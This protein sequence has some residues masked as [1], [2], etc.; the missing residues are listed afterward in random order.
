[1]SKRKPLPPTYLISSIIAMLVLNFVFP[2]SRVIRFP[3]NLL[4]IVPLAIGIIVNLVADKA[5]KKTDTTVKPFE[6]STTLITTGVFRISRH[7]MYVGMVLILIGIAVLMGSLTP[8]SVI[9]VFV[10]LME[11]VFIRV[12]ERMLEEKFGGAWSAYKGKVR[13]WI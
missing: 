2:V 5:F 3:W 10:V 1:M 9:F 7:P 13:R 8:Y 11:I 6:D 4:G 12:E